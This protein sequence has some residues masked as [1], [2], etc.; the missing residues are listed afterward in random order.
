[1][2]LYPLLTMAWGLLLFTEFK[3]SS[4]RAAVLLGAMCCT[5]MLGVGLLGAARNFSTVQ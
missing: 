4:K 1:M 5:Y 2:K 3:G